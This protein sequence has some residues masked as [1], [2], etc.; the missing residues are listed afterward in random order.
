MTARRSFLARLGAAGATLGFAGAP[1]FASPRPF[2][3]ERAAQEKAPAAPRFE[4]ARHEKDDWMELPG[5][6]RLVFDGTSPEGV[7]DALQFTSN[8]FS[9]NRNGY[10]LEASDVA[11]LIVMRHRATQFAF[12]DAVWSKYGAA[13]S[14]SEEF[15]DPK[16]KQAPVVN[17]YRTQIE[18]N[19]KRGVHIGACDLSAHRLASFIARKTQ[20]KAD[21]VYKELVA[22][23]MPNVH[24]VPAGIVC[25]SRAQERGYTVSYAG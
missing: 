7:R 12:T 25:L 3:A 21:D 19:A 10:A 8:F 24:F 13:L 1:A 14:E 16:T 6:H 22:N 2:A 4:P 20:A 15:V 5:K 18:N 9:G 17:V 23:A 11:V